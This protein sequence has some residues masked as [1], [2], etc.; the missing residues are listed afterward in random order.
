MKSQ[1]EEASYCDQHLCGELGASES[2]DR[3]APPQPGSRGGPLNQ[4]M[5]LWASL[6]PSLCSGGG[7]RMPASSM[8][9]GMNLDLETVGGAEEAGLHH[10]AFNSAAALCF[11]LLAGPQFPHLEWGSCYEAWRK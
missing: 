3:G 7:E 6:L 4:A 1:R 8:G 10:V 5:W 2:W 11:A 9:S